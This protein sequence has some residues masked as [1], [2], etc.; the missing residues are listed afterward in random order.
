M[1]ESVYVELQDGTRKQVKVRLLEHE[2]V[3]RRR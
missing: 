3:P 1:Q 2:V